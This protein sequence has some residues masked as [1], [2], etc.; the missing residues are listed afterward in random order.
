[1]RNLQ[2]VLPTVCGMCQK[3]WG[4]GSL[5]ESCWRVKESVN[6]EALKKKHGQLYLDI[7][8]GDNPHPGAVAMDKRA[9]ENI[10]V[11]HEIE[12][13]PWPFP[14]DSFDKIIASHVI[15]HLK[16][17]CMVDV[18]DEAWRVMK[19]DGE[20]LIAMPYAGSFGFYQDPTHTKAWNE[21]TPAYF[22]PE[23]KG[24]HLYQVYKPKP[25]R[26][27]INTWHA[28]GNMEV[29]LKKRAEAK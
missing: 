6:L 24:G 20:F 14:P 22:D 7:G 23:Y 19:V 21:A 18:M 12:D 16:P 27:L 13:T 5:H 29:V 11:V 1:M 15:E 3:P 4:D 10:D 26:V 8:A 2:K 25:W 17:W 9:R 28:D